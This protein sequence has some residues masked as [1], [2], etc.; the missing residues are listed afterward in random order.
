MNPYAQVPAFPVAR[1]SSC[2]QACGVLLPAPVGTGRRQDCK[3][4][5]TLSHEKGPGAKLPGLKRE[6][7]FK[8]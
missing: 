6:A 2:P 3:W 5:A 7:D 1:Y 8:D 4:T